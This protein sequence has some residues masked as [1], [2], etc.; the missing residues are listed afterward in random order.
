MEGRRR[1]RRSTDGRQVGRMKADPEVAVR[2]LERMCTCWPLSS[3]TG[4]PK[5]MVSKGVGRHTSV[6]QSGV[7]F[8]HKEVM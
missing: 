3:R 7:T 4:Q 5:V 2:R 6:S 8:F 1:K